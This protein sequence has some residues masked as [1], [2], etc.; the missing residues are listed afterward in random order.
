MRTTL[1]LDEDVAAKLRAEARASGR[2]FRDVVNDAI[3]QGLASRYVA[4]SAEPFRVTTRDLGNLRPG[5]SLD[6]IGDLLE[7][8]EGPLHR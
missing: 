7:R 5:L 1:T 2:S 3:R 6:D 8:V 4:E